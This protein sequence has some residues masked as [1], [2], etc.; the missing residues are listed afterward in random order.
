[1]SFRY[2]LLCLVLLSMVS[3]LGLRSYE[4][5]NAPVPVTHDK[6]V[7]KRPAEKAPDGTGTA[8]EKTIPSVE[9]SILLAEKNIFSPERK[10]FP[11]PPSPQAGDK[12]RM[13]RPQVFLYGVTL[14]GNYQ[15]ASIVQTGRTLRK[16][17]RETMNLKVGEKIGEYKLTKVLPDR[18]TLEGEG[19]SFEV[20]LY[21]PE[22]IKRRSE[23]KPETKPAT[24]TSTVPSPPAAKPP[25]VP[26]QAVRPSLPT[27]VT[28]PVVSPQTGRETSPTPSPFSRRRRPLPGTPSSP[29]TPR[30]PENPTQPNPPQESGGN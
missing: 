30:T 14:A 13:A 5:W 6:A 29:V 8:G 24:V 17:E 3:F 18:I 16:D 27:P 2:A 25:Q 22:K 7:S 19:D 20:L 23:V 10:E 26:G 11:T 9:S 4:I 15:S 21:D 12:S 1:M 28:P